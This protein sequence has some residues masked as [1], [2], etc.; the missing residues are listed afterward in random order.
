[1]AFLEAKQFTMLL[2]ANLFYAASVNLHYRDAGFAIL[3]FEL[4]HLFC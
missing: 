2:G 3:P 4:A 1:M